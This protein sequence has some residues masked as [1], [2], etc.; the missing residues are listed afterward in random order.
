M[1][2]IREDAAEIGLVYYPPA[3]SHITARGSAPAHACH[4]P[5]PAP[6]GQRTTHFASE[7]N[8]WPIAMLQG[9]YGIRQLIEYAEHADKIHLS[10]ALTSNL[11]SVLLAFVSSGQGV[12]LLPPAPSRPLWLAAA[13]APSP[14]TTRRSRMQRCSSSPAPANIS[15][16]PPTVF[17]CTACRAFR[18]FRPPVDRLVNADS[19]RYCLFYSPSFQWRPTAVPEHNRRV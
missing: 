18:R 5:C 9:V 6:T 7:L 2:R 10:P 17:C 15:R 4:R 11:I 14:F 19:S 13:C 8:Q 16:P 1:R 3:D 12:T